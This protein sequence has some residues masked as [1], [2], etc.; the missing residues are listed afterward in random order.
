M[1]R[2]MT[3][4]M[5]MRDRKRLLVGPGFKSVWPTT[6]RQTGFKA[7]A[8]VY[9]GPNCEIAPNTHVGDFTMIS[10]NVAIVGGDHVLDAIGIPSQ[11]AG[12]PGWPT[13]TIGCDVLV[14][15]ASIIMAGRRVGDAAVIASGS[16][17]TKDVP[18]GAVVGG[19]PAEFI[20]WRFGTQAGFREH[21]SSLHLPSSTRRSRAPR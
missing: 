8:Y 10:S 20:R 2:L 7:G 3:L 13:T 14:G 5:T 9:I 11:F 1:S 18:P 4:I 15:K 17:V 16:V 12:R 19:N 6:I 21:L